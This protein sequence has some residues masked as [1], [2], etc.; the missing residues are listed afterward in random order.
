M[1][2]L[3]FDEL[4]PEIQKRL[5]EEHGVRKPRAPRKMTKE[6]IRRRALRVLSGISDLSQAD[7]NRVLEFAITL[8][9]V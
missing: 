5:R 7:R 1:P 8:N 3:N 9:E 4:S 6:V 2:K